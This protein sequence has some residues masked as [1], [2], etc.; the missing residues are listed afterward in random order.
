MGKPDRHEQIT[1][2]SLDSFLVGIDVSAETLEVAYRDQRGRIVRQT[3]ENAP[4]RHGALVRHLEKRARK[5]TV[6]VVL[7][8][9]GVYHLEAA[10]ALDRAGFE[11]MV[12]NPRAA[13]HY[14]KAKLQRSKTDQLDAEMLL[15]FAGSMSFVRWQ[16]PEPAVLELRVIARRIH[17]LT[18][19]VAG[20]KNRDHAAEQTAAIRTIERSIASVVRALEKELARLRAEALKVI[21]SDMVLARRFELLQSV[22]GIAEKSGIAILA[23]LSV[24][25]ADMTDR[26][27]VAHAGLDP[28]QFE[29]GTSV[30]AKTKI[31]KRGNKYL[32]AALYKPAV[33]ACTHQRGVDLFAHRLRSRGKAP[34]LVHV[35]VMR[36]LLVAIHGMFVTDQPF[37]G[38]RFTPAA[39]V[40]VETAGIAS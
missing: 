39:A 22:K 33:T 9:T 8:A 29:S 35:A 1:E 14:A 15:A 27:W 5:A 32:R 20:E 37:D 12:V 25:P 6:R 28:R 40:A 24:L 31:S 38:R 26:Q 19:V 36:K 11:V 10:L 16:A 23:E 13:S 21:Q 30:R 18:V 17:A 3:F 7:E 2:A 34:L 4:A